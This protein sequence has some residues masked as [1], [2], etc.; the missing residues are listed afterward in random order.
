M[1]SV[2]VICDL[3][4]LIVKISC[5]KRRTSLII[6]IIG[7]V[8]HLTICSIED[9]LT[10]TALIQLDF[11]LRNPMRFFVIPTNHI[12]EHRHTLTMRQQFQML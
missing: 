7:I 10:R 1:Q 6:F 2:D 4:R 11:V 9:E 12:L 5:E 3:L 8:I